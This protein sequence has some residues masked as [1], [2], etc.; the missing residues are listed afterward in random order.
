MI[1][2]TGV[3]AIT[4]PEG[5]VKKITRGAT[6]LWEKPSGDNNDNYEYIVVL[7]LTTIDTNI[8]D[9]TSYGFCEL[10]DPPVVGETY[11]SIVNG[12]EHRYTAIE[13]SGDITICD[14]N[15]IYV[16]YFD[17]DEYPYILIGLD[18]EYESITLEIRLVTG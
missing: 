17:D 8:D 2:F 15:G 18:S 10:S 12:V 11:I 6:V 7:P 5:S 4:I 16:V 1:D 14:T 3:K 9:G 13:R